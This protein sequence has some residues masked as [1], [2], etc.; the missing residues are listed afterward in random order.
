MCMYSQPLVTIVVFALNQHMCLNI[1]ACVYVYIY[2]YYGARHGSCWQICP[3]NR[4][5]CSISAWVPRTEHHLWHLR[6]CEP[7]QSNSHTSH[8]FP[9]SLVARSLP[10]ILTKTIRWF[11]APAD[12]TCSSLQQPQKWY[13]KQLTPAGVFTLGDLQLMSFPFK[14]LQRFWGRRS[15]SLTVA[16]PEGL[17]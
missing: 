1:R 10:R 7:P 2:I 17:N 4:C 12:V 5:R 9:Y 14:D 11:Q 3:G 13:G 6:F 15:P 16:T 8:H